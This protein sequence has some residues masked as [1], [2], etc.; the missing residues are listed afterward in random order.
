MPDP[1]GDARVDLHLHTTASDGTLTP[2]ELVER[3]ASLGVAAIAITDHDSM[4]GVAEGRAAGERLGVEVVPG[5]EIGIAH[6][7]AR[8]L[9]EVD[10]LGYYIDPGDEEFAGVTRDLQGAKNGKLRSQIEV[11]AANGLPIRIEEVLE[12]AAGDTVRRPH[13]WKILHRHHPD[14]PP[15]EFFNRTSFGGDWHVPKTFSLSLE[16]CVALIERVGGVPV[17]AH[18]GAYN[19]TFAKDGPLIDRGVDSTIAVCAGA[20]VRG[21]E[22]FYP[23][24]KGRPYHDG[25]PLIDAAELDSLVGHY[26]TL[27]DDHG[28]LATGGTDFHG[29]SKPQ[30]E[31]GE[32]E[33]PYRLLQAT[34]PGAQ[35]G[36][37]EGVTAPGSPYSIAKLGILCYN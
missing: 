29:A 7:P 15:E 10:V 35:G 14:F 16:D 21:L 34:P 27:A 17:L 19:T 8:N 22:V 26:E 24:N 12:E 36:G 6:D 23:Y 32:V 31:L 2:T 5:I 30:I 3:A 33:V 4:A 18:P 13:I 20:G 28:L 11:L 37:R 25:V 1:R 9:I